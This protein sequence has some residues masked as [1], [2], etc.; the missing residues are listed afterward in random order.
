MATGEAT[1]AEIA[2]AAT[3]GVLSTAQ[4]ERLRTEKSV[5]VVPGDHFHLDGWFRLGLGE[6]T[7]ALERGLRRVSETLATL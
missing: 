3:E 1:L 5:L 2:T 6:P 7:D 4:A